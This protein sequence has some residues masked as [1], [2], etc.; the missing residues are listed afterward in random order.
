M[1]AIGLLVLVFA[2][3]A[4]AALAVERVRTPHDVGRVETAGGRIRGAPPAFDALGLTADQR[5]RLDSLFDAHRRRTEEI[6]REPLRALRADVEALRREAAAILTP[7]QRA[8]LDTILP[9]FPGRE[10]GVG[11]R[12]GGDSIAGPVEGRGVRRVRP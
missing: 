9:A 1:G 11:V 7:A 12:V 2:S 8:A 3:G 4:A 5:A 10:G 6:M